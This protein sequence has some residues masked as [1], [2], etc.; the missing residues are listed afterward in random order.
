M[1]NNT[2]VSDVERHF[3]DLEK[4]LQD[5]GFTSDSQVMKTTRRLLRSLRGDGFAF[6]GI[7]VEITPESVDVKPDDVQLA[8]E[9]NYIEDTAV[10][11]AFRTRHAFDT[12]VITSVFASIEGW[13]TKSI[14]HKGSHFVVATNAESI[15]ETRIRQAIVDYVSELKQASRPHE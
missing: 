14:E 3:L 7:K 1:A 8:S 4:Q 5:D 9:D 13:K 10:V 6:E 15:S 2:S 12:A 11:R